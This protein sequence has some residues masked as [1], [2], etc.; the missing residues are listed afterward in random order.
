MPD[1]LTF[2][3]VHA[4]PDDESIGTGGALARYAEEGIRTVL[5]MPEAYGTPDD[6]GFVHHVPEATA[7]VS[8]G[9]HTEPVKLPAM[10]RVLGGDRFFDLPDE[11]GGELEIPLRYL[12]AGVTS[13]GSGRL[14]ARQY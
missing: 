8:T 2:M 6:P 1:S 4:H 9:R 7:I 5:V 14:T 12:Y 13:T 3:T 11:P 10:R